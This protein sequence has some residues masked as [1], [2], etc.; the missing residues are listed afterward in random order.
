M[1]Y[2]KE[3]N[4]KIVYK[5]LSEIAIRIHGTYINNP[6]EAL[7]IADGWKLYVPPISNPNLEQLKEIKK[8]EI[9]NYDS[10]SEVN[11]FKIQND[12]IWLDKATR[13][14]L[15]L[16]FQSEKQAGNLITTLWYNNKSYTLN[17]ETAISMLN[18]LEL[19][20]SKC[21]DIT[22]QHLNKIKDLSTIE[23]VN[24]Y[25]YKKDYPEILQF[26]SYN[27]LTN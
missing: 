3:I 8:E 24:N 5:K 2:Y 19:Y 21:Y 12:E 1:Y 14:G 13:V 4:G 20:A 23:E 9:I 6:G 17:L 16:R 22:Q 27:E 26:D 7:V 15:S 10:S 25:D 11:V 18:A